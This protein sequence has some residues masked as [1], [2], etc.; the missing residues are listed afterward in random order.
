MMSLREWL[1]HPAAPYAVPFAVFML[2]LALMP[3]LPISPVASLALGAIIAGGSLIGLSRSVLDFRPAMPWWSIA[4]GV[5][6]F[7]LWIGPDS[8][9]PG[10]R[11]HWLFQNSLTG[12]AKSS[13]SSDSLSD[14]A[15]LALRVLRAVLIV[16]IVEELFWRGWL[17][18]WI[19]KPDFLSVPLGSYDARS[20]WLVAALFAMEHGPYW[21]VGFATGAVYNWWMTRTKRLSD[22]ILMHFITNACLCAYVIKAGRWEYWL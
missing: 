3:R 13:L 20:F 5:A 6:V 22:L 2:L 12:A 16:P 21:D 1:R 11:S 8:L 10:W 18:R 19:E 15:V 14:P 9:I 7:F 4:L 17:M